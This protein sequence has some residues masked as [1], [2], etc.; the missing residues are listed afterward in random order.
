MRC[1]PVLRAA[2]FVELACSFVAGVL[3]CAA[4][5]SADVDIETCPALVGSHPEAVPGKA[6]TYAAILYAP[7]ARSVVATLGAF[8]DR[9]FFTIALPEQALKPVSTASPKPFDRYSYRAAPLA[10]R[11]PDSVTVYELWVHDARATAGDTD[12]VKSGAAE[13]TA[14]EGDPRVPYVPKIDPAATPS[15]TP[16]P[17]PTVD[18]AVVP[19]VAVRAPDLETLSCPRPFV[20]ARAVVPVAPDYPF[21][22]AMENATSLVEIT[23]G[24][25]GTP[26][27]SYVYRPSSELAFDIATVQAAMHTTYAPAIAFCRPIYSRYIFHADFS[28][29]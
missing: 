5:A 29:K 28:S 23:I 7:G 27:G 12:W 13:C 24:P 8:T 1:R 17:L 14:P 25:T 15:P 10:V 19:I 26:V 16:E 11:F 20:N 9:G 22:R 6:N 18:P 4:R 2:L 3:A 21:A